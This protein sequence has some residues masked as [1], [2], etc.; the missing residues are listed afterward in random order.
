V[1][2][3]PSI[4]KLSLPLAY[5]PKK[6]V[7]FMTDV[8]V[9]G[10][11]LAGCTVAHHLSEIASVKLFEKSKSLGGRIATRVSCDHQFDHGAQF[12]TARSSDFKDFL[13]PLVDAGC[14]AR[15]DA[16][17][18]E[19]DGAQLIRQTEWGGSP[20]HWVGMP[21]M[22]GFV[23][24]L[25]NGLDCV[26]DVEVARVEKEKDRW[27]LFDAQGNL[28]GDYDW[29]IL[30]APAP[31]THNLLPN[32]ISFKTQV[33]LIKMLGC[34]SLMLG[35]RHAVNLPFDAALV[36]NAS[37]SWI[38]VNSSKPNRKNFSILV[39]STNRWAEQ[40]MN[41]DLAE[42]QEKL[43][44]FTSEI[45]GFNVKSADYIETKRWRF[46]NSIRQT[47]QPFFLDR[48]NQVA[49]C[50]DW[51]IRGRIEAAFLSAKKLAVDLLKDF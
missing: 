9:I 31:Q 51:C 45:L 20:S 34:Y 37:I 23:E 1:T 41:T 40:N 48:S 32:E 21:T 17:F 6:Y 19:F 12:F 50:G 7:L 13:T 18:A 49:S 8:A 29:I 10:A 38:S 3:A 25:S 33:G 15:W 28:L 16:R 47:D 43:F 27:I 42:V 30:T 4:C 14:V 36:K 11:G 26:F 44:E 2:G 39:H 24:R 46:A 35:Y 5:K 22:S